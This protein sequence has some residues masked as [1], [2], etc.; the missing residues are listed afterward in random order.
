VWRFCGVNEFL[1]KYK[2]LGYISVGKRSFRVADCNIFSVSPQSF[3]PSK[4]SDEENLYK[5]IAVSPRRRT[6]NLVV[7][8]FARLGGH[9]FA[10]PSNPLHFQNQ[11]AN[12]GS[13]RICDRELG[14]LD[15]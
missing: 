6:D 11:L 9:N 13:C 3:D 15:A 14:T 4:D 8:I 7:T 10:I 12:H 1:A 5:S 2:L